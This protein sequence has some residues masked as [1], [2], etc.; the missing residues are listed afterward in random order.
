M[1]FTRRFGNQQATVASWGNEQLD[2]LR[3]IQTRLDEIAQ[4]LKDRQA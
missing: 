3:G 1:L 2:V 4:L